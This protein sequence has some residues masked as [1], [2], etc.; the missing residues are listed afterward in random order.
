[1]APRTSDFVLEKWRS[2][3]FLSLWLVL[4]ISLFAW[5]FYQYKRRSAFEVMGYCVCIAK[6]AAETLKLNMAFIFLP[7]RRNTLARLRSTALS[8]IIPFDDNINFHKV[9]N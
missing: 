4:N 2:I 6:G 9:T 7:I 8:S 1:M 5:K 3:W